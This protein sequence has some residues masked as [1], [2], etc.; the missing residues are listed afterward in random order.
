MYA[1]RLAMLKPAEYKDDIGNS[2]DQWHSA[3]CRTVKSLKVQILRESLTAT[4]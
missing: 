3:R 4:S 1:S 2:S